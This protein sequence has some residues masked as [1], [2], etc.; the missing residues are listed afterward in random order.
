MQI[1]PNY[2]CGVVHVV[3]NISVD[4]YLAKHLDTIMFSVP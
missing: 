1:V 2:G 3:Q 4:I